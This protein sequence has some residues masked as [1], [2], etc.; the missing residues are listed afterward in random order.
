MRPNYY[1]VTGYGTTDVYIK[2]S[3]FIAY[4]ERVE[5]EDE[6]I[7]FIEKIKKKHH[8]ATHNCSAYTVGPKHQIQKANDDGEPSGTAGIPILEV[9]LKRNLEDTVV[10]ITRYFGGIKL[11][12]GG[13]IRAYG[14]STTRGIDATGV[15]YREKNDI[16][17]VTID[18]TWLGKIENE[19]RQSTYTIKEID[20]TNDV[21]MY[22]YVPLE[23][24][25]SFTEWMTEMTNGQATIA[26]VDTIFREIPQ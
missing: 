25:E 1:T 26:T 10:V 18:Y 8:D 4:V 23:K 14:Q 24:K 21:T 3:Q 13:L 17:G 5:T 9:L 6:A 16:I 11:G 7:A 15:V 19:V 12:S 2:K 22:I 20:Y